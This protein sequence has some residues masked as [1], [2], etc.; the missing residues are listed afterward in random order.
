MFS[1][2]LSALSP[3][4]TTDIS[5]WTRHLSAQ[6]EQRHRQFGSHRMIDIDALVGRSAQVIGQHSAKA[7]ADKIWA[8]TIVC[9][10]RT[11]V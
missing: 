4:S 1:P 8:A 2:L 3:T 7:L 10:E 6:I 5:V 11:F 9:S